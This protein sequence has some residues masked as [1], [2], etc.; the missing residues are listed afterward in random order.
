MFDEI[1]KY[2]NNG[3]FFFQKG[4]SLL[5]VSAGV[6]ELPGVYYIIKLAHGRVDL[7]YIGKSGTMEQNG[8]FKNQLLKKRLNNK[9]ENMRREDFF[10]KKI[11]E[12]NIDALDIYW[13]VTFDKQNHDLPAYVEGLLMQRYFEVHGKLPEWNKDF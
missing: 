7:V 8:H 12:E 11:E 4:V 6:P 3:H 1:K 9:Q 5:E 2:K 10:L 13:F